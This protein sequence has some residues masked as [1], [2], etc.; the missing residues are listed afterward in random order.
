MANKSVVY[1]RI[2]T[3]LKDNAESILAKLGISPSGVI[4]MLYSQIVLHNGIPFELTL[5]TAKPTAVGAMSREELNAELMK[6]VDSLKK[7][8][9]VI[10]ETVRKHSIDEN[11]REEKKELSSENEARRM[12]AALGI[13]G[14]ASAPARTAEN[15]KPQS[16]SAVSD[17]IDQILAELGTQS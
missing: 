12:Q 6:G 2:D 10:M 11:R 14:Q 8:G 13:G 1:A 15:D 9:S 5:P 17:E 7:S 16:F 3:G 4:Q